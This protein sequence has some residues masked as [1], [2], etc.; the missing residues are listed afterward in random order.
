MFILEK[1]RKPQKLEAHARA[2]HICQ[3]A[4][5]VCKI[6]G[7]YRTKKIVLLGS[8]YEKLSKPLKLS[9]KDLNILRFSWLT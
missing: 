8:K 1:S 3:F 7:L 5:S 2:K 9:K 4:V 6:K